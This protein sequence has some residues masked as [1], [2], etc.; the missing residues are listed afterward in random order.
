MTASIVKISSSSSKLL[1][2]GFVVSCKKQ[3]KYIITCGHVVNNCND[4]LFADKMKANILANEYDNG[5]D[6][7][8]L[9]VESL[10]KPPLT[11]KD[12]G[13]SE[14]AKVIGY[15]LLG[16]D[17]KLEHVNNIPVKTGI[18][19][20]KI[21]DEL[22]YIRLNPD[23]QLSHGYSGSP[24]I[25]TSTGLVIGVVTTQVAKDSNYAIS[26]NYIANLL[27][28]KSQPN[29]PITRVFPV[30][31][32]LTSMLSEEE[33]SN[34]QNKLQNKFEQAMTLFSSR[35]QTWLEPAL[36]SIPE[37]N[38]KRD[39]ED[40]LSTI[41][42]LILN[43]KNTIIFARPQYGLS[44]LAHN[45]I[46]QAWKKT[47]KAY[48]LYI[49]FSNV[50]PYDKEINK[51]KNKLLDEYALSNEDIE[52]I[53]VDN[54]HQD[55]K[56]R[57]TKF[58]K[59]MEN[60]PSTPCI[61]LYQY[62]NIGLTDKLEIDTAGISFDSYFLWALPRS[63]IRQ[64]V[65]DYN[66]KQYVGNEDALVSTVAQDLIALNIPRTPLNCLTLLKI[67]EKTYDDSPV[68]R[69][70]MIRR[71]LFLLFN[72]DEIPTYKARPDLKDTEFILGYLCEILLTNQQQYFS[73]EYFLKTLKNFCRE[74][75]LDIDVGVIFD[76]LFK[77]S[78]IIQSD[79]DFCF[80]FTYYV[81]YFAAHR[82]HMSEKFADHVLSDMNYSQFPEILEFYTGIDRKRDDALE[83]MASDINT[84]LNQIK[85]KSGIQDI[86]ELY[87]LAIWDPSPESIEKMQN[88]VAEEIQSSKLPNDLKDSFADTG[89][90]TERPHR[91]NI[92][93]LF[94]TYSIPRLI[95]A[96]SAASK[97]LRNSDYSSTV[98]RH[99]LLKEILAAWRVITSI[100]LTLAPV[101]VKE[102]MASME[103]AKF[104]FVG[105]NFPTKT[106]KESEE[107]LFF[108]KFISIFECI[109][110]NI[111]EWN[112]E[113][114]YSNKMGPM[115]ASHLSDE[116]HELSKHMLMVLFAKK[117]PSNWFKH[118]RNYITTLDKN[119]YY[120]N[121]I[122][123]TLNEEIR[124]GF[125]DNREFKKLG[126]LLTM[127]VAKHQLGIKK[128][129]QKVIDKHYPNIVP[130]RNDDELG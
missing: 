116:E 129:S 70:D 121:N 4:D 40:H 35:P 130:K 1:G 107:H 30:Y 103:G 119:S 94:Q 50:K 67:Y 56:D 112:I 125:V 97:A 55:E 27:D 109:P 111:L 38:P 93:D 22:D 64:M 113:D 57:D 86:F 128:P 9:Q 48:W 19:I 77:N 84:Q 115:L 52:C 120:L 47:N 45:L 15:S 36:H 11:I 127:C 14:N 117:R 83:I 89:Y 16:K 80:K 71:V 10:S 91:Q 3:H 41:N 72:G 33:K 100:L 54:I 60:F 39:C 21:G 82:M 88:K 43:P 7:A 62:E 18:K 61:A 49:D 105:D 23:Q 34:I 87:D 26:S 46:L 2:T 53:V 65:S 24:V 126:Q 122:Q 66:N 28:I 110:N 42:D 124:Y 123:Y 68:N 13:K 81:F 31:A 6:L 17:P 96:V 44:S 37:N 73:R 58:S 90:D 8:V 32:G 99:N 101:L 95:G 20:E 25:C 102:G 79:L 5:L 92:Q 118:L 29:G 104:I 74:N 85:E 78:I 59:I 108:R 106:P 114:I 98:S 69:T 12:G 51:L 75:E 63:K 76:I